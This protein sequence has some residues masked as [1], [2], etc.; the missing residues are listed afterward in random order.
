MSFIHKFKKI[1]ISSQNTT[2]LHSECKE[3]HLKISDSEQLQR[4]EWGLVHHEITSTE[5]AKTAILTANKGGLRPKSSKYGRDLYSGENLNSQ[6]I[7]V[8]NLYEQNRSLSLRGTL[9]GFLISFPL[10][11]K[12]P[13]DSSFK[14][15]G[16]SQVP[17]FI[18]LT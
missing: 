16:G 6:Y 17:L 11:I 4:K 12:P 5:K 2:L 7:T 3:R 14:S 9:K 18:E 8:M 15:T 1:Q 10:Y 13:K